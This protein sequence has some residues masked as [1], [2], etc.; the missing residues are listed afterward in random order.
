VTVKCQPR[1][2]IGPL[3][4]MSGA[5]SW[6]DFAQRCGYPDCHRAS[7]ARWFR[8]GVTPMMA[9]RLAVA[10]GFHP[11]EVWGRDWYALVDEEA[12]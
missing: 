1:L 8:L 2:P 9:D 10:C 5:E 4:R 7:V 12:A 3:Y 6:N 11:A